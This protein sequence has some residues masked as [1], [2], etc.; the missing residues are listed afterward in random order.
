MKQ[1]I[2]EILDL[3]SHPIKV[4]TK[5]GEG[6]LTRIDNTT[7]SIN[8]YLIELVSGVHKGESIAI[9]E[10]EFTIMREENDL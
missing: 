7:Y 4:L 2:N 9:T 1:L 10:K 3:N 6:L 5:H 8:I